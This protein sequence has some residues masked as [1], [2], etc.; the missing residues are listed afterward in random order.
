MYLSEKK[1]FE[2]IKL[3][4][5]NIGFFSKKKKNIGQCNVK[6]NITSRQINLG[7]CIRFNV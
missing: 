2:N 1:T 3:S 5:K 7:E 4:K 6:I